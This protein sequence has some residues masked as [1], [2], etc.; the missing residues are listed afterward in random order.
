MSEK[1]RRYKRKEKGKINPDLIERLFFALNSEMLL[2]KCFLLKLRRF[3][4]RLCA[5]KC[6]GMKNKKCK[7][8]PVLLSILTV[9]VTTVLYLGW[10][11][12]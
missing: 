2:P 9:H 7:Q 10:G 8:R 5:L 3:T 4:V 12:T 6:F 11:N 1:K